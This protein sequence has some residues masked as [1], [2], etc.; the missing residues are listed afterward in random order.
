MKLCAVKNRKQNIDENEEPT[1]ATRIVMN[2]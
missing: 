2:K 1:M